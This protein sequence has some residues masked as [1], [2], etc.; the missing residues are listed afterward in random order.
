MINVYGVL[1]EQCKEEL[2]QT[3]ANLIDDKTSLKE[4]N[5]SLTSIG[6][7]LQKEIFDLKQVRIRL[8]SLQVF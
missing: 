8:N 1:F 5:E 6:S 4:Q 3:I 7:M 2:G